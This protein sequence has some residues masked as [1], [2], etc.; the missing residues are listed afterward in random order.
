MGEPNK[1]RMDRYDLSVPVF[2]LPQSETELNTGA[3]IELRT[4]NI[5]SGGAFFI[6]DNPFQIDTKLDIDIRI[7]LFDESSNRVR[8]SDVHVTGS[9]IRINTTGMAV[10]FDKK[11]QIVSAG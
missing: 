1:R 2:V 8:K 5:S 11:F 3:G 7:A 4:R 10:K 9:V 6:T